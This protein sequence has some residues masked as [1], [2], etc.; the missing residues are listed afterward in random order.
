MPAS[1]PTKLNQPKVTRDKWQYTTNAW[2]KERHVLIAS[3]PTN[4][5]LRRPSRLLN[6]SPATTPAEST[7]GGVRS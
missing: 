3:D 7:S 1:S 2:T 4:E 6:K 5:L